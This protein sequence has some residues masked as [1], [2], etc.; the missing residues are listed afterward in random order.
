M[1]CGGAS[2]P[3]L[4][5]IAVSSAT[6]TASRSP[7]KLACR[8][9]RCL[10]SSDSVIDRDRRQKDP[11]R[12]T[13]ATA[14]AEEGRGG[15]GSRRVRDCTL[16]SLKRLLVV[17]GWASNRHGRRAHCHGAVPPGRTI[18]REPALVNGPRGVG[19]REA[20]GAATPVIPAAANY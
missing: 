2:S 7:L 11:V 9:L 17:G 15:Q 5:S 18:L 1:L 6:L 16:V 20:H 4:G 3:T 10:A 14:T 12:A 13:A 19:P 8:K